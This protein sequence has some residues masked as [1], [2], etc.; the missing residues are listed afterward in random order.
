MPIR[1]RLTLWYGLLLGVTLVLFCLALY[2]SLRAA[3]ERDFDEI[4]RVRAQQVER[5]LA[6]RS[7]EGEPELTAGEISFA[8]LEPTALEEFAEPDVYVQVLSPRGEVLASSGTSLPFNPVLVAEA[9]ARD[10]AF[11]TLAIGHLRQLRTLY[12]P[13]RVDGR[14]I[15][16]VQVAGLVGVLLVGLWNAGAGGAAVI[17]RVATSALLG[18][19]ALVDVAPWLSWRVPAPPAVAS[20]P[21]RSLAAIHRRCGA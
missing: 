5:D 15:A 2:L 3:L 9:D 7:R 21:D 19:S 8:D 10:G 6:N 16:V 11:D 1:V 13:V 20:P 14:L 17:A 12:W 18:S 4:L